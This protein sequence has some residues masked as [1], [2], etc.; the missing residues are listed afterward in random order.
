MMHCVYVNAERGRW[1]IGRGVR[2]CWAGRRMVSALWLSIVWTLPIQST[3]F[4]N[5]LLNLYLL[6]A[7]PVLPT[8]HAERHFVNETALT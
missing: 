1:Q 7:S 5:P 2:G 8:L 3:I 4:P 6:G